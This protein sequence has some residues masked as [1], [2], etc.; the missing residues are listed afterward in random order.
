M[1]EQL[2]TRD[3]LKALA[4]SPPG[5]VLSRLSAHGKLAKAATTTSVEVE[6]PKAR[7]QGVNET[8]K[9]TSPIMASSAPAC[10]RNGHGKSEQGPSSERSCCRRRNATH[11]HKG[12]ADPRASAANT[13]TSRDAPREAATTRMRRRPARAALGPVRVARR[14]ESSRTIATGALAADQSR[15]ATRASFVR[16]RCFPQQNPS[17][18]WGRGGDWVR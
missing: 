5:H 6:L 9:S 3:G 12:A 13:A 18:N 8:P 4:D 11:R 14:R 2:E 17:G 16:E 7:A 1:S 15:K 10:G